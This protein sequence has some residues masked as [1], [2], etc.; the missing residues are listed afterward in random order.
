M[1]IISSSIS[2]NILR[3]QRGYRPFR[4]SNVRISSW[5]SGFT[6]EIPIRN[7]VSRSYTTMDDRA[8]LHVAALPQR[9][10]S[11]ENRSRIWKKWIRGDFRSRHRTIRI[12]YVYIRLGKYQGFSSEVSTLLIAEPHSQKHEANQRDS[13]GDLTLAR[14]AELVRTF[15]LL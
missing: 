7:S 9:F 15:H 4:R 13:P 11:L 12:S 10:I 8:V 14:Y 3:G 1:L 5:R 2:C 6:C